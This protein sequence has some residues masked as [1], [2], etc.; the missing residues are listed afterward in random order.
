MRPALIV[1]SATGR[2]ALSKCE[3]CAEE[4]VTAAE[5][6]L[7]KVRVEDSGSQEACYRLAM[8]CDWHLRMAEEWARSIR[9]PSPRM[10]NRAMEVTQRAK[11]AI[12]GA[13]A[14]MQKRMEADEG[15]GGS[16]RGSS[17]RRRRRRHLADTASGYLVGT[18]RN[19]RGIGLI[20]GD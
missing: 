20:S 7:R 17:K 2:W 16:D 6:L 14:A 13:T 11:D 19:R 4:A 9:S 1:K 8:D 3:G 5:E 10:E 12:G 18:R 15:R